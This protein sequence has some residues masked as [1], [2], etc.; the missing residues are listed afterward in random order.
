M[1]RVDRAAEELAAQYGRARVTRLDD[2]HLIV[3]MTDD[4]ERTHLFVPDDG[5]PRLASRAE[6]RE[7]HRNA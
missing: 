3:G 2:G 7:G 1:D 6:I 4:V 5:D